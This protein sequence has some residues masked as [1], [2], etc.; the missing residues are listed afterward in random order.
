MGLD[1]RT[2]SI[3]SMKISISGATAVVA[4]SAEA[5][6]PAWAVKAG[7]GLPSSRPSTGVG[8]ASAEKSLRM[9]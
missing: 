1:V 7:I 9:S 3:A 2:T 6:A 5:M 8:A 4:R